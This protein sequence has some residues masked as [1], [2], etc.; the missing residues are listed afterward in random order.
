MTNHTDNA[1]M[2]TPTGIGGWLI[3]PILGFVVVFFSILK[4]ILSIFESQNLNGLVLIFNTASNDPLA[5]LKLPLALS[6]LSGCLVIASAAY[7]L[8]LVFSKNQNIIKF[9]TVHY[10]ILACAG[11]IELW[12]GIVSESTLP[13]SPLDK[14]A[15]KDAF[16]GVIYG[17]VWISYFKISKRVK[18]TFIKK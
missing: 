12:A 1:I 8:Y 5:A 9:A 7:C 4:N 16:Q 10:I 14:S 17:I 13:N 2:K 3:L 18:N 15:I 11:I 6:F